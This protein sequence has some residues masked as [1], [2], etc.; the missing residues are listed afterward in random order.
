MEA[1][2]RPAF[3]TDSSVPRGFK[4][5]EA[6]PSTSGFRLLGFKAIYGFE[7]ERVSRCTDRKCSPSSNPNKLY[8]ISFMGVGLQQGQVLKGA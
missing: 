6:A 2:E 3:R 5:D 7:L 4:S 1:P 8:L